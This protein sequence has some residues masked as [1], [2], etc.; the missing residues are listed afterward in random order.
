MYYPTFLKNKDTIGI[1]ALS[2]GVG[3]KLDSFNESIQYIHTQGFQTKETSDVRSN[4]EPS[5]DAKIRVKEF[6]TLLEDTSISAIW[7]AAGGDFQV[8][9]MP[10]IDFDSIKAHPKWFLGASDPTNLLF[11]V[12]C[13]CDIATIYGFNAGSFDAYGINAYSQSCFYFLKGNNQPL[14]SSTKHQHVDFYN[15]G[16]PILN[17]STYYQGEVS[18]KARLLGGCLES[19]NDLAGTPFDFTQVFIQRYENDG[20]VWFFD[21]FSMNSCDVYRALLKMKILNYFQTTKA[22]LVGRVLF[23]NVSELINYHEA[24]QRACPNIPLIFETDI[25]HTYPHFYVI[26]G[27]LAQI[28][29]KQGKGNIQYILK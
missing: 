12:T 25:G 23:E 10:Y 5:A 11:P 1:T 17:T 6:N 3:H 22:I 18:V 24:F 21:I 27:A 7:C 8:E 15:E 16:A 4:T 26:N 2:S 28:D 29:V 13:H 20:I 14:V 9:T 19:I